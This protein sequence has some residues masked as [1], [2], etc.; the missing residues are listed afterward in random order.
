MNSRNELVATLYD[1]FNH[2]NFEE[3]LE[4]SSLSTAQARK[5]QAQTPPEIYQQVQDHLQD[6]EVT[7]RQG[8]VDDFLLHLVR[9]YSAS[10]DTEPISSALIDIAFPTWWSWMLRRWLWWCWDSSETPEGSVAPNHWESQECHSWNFVYVASHVRADVVPCIMQNLLDEEVFLYLRQDVARSMVSLCFNSRTPLPLV[11]MNACASAVPASSYRDEL[12]DAFMNMMPTEPTALPAGSWLKRTEIGPVSS[13]STDLLALELATGIS[14]VDGGIVQLWDAYTESRGRKI[15]HGVSV[16]AVTF[17]PE[18]GRL[19]TDD[20]DGDAQ[21]WNAHGGK[22]LIRIDH[23][24]RVHGVAFSSKK[25]KFMIDSSDLIW[26]WDAG[27]GTELSTL[28]SGPGSLACLFDDV[29]FNLD[30]CLL[31]AA[32]LTTAAE[33]TA[34]E[35]IDT[36]GWAEALPDLASVV[37]AGKPDHA[38]RLEVVLED[39]LRRLGACG[40]PIDKMLSM[41]RRLRGW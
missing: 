10:N 21:I 18:S 34:R 2:E 39:F 7:D 25:R 26:I 40:T 13:T 4:E 28:S 37:A 41:L 11:I 1:Q 32:A 36:V 29:A 22:L 16:W 19:A 24:D 20:S 9:L 38:V 31:A 14:I 30:G 35:P 33:T 15:T 17:S 27:P 23:R 5:N 6:S 12:A 3:L 8:D